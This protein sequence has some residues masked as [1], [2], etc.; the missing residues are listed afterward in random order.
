ME[1]T[2]VSSNHKTFVYDKIAVF[3]KHTDYHG[4]VHPYNFLE[5]MSYTREAYFSKVCEDFRAILDSPVKMMT[6]KVD[7]TNYDDAIFGDPI[8]AKLTI[9]KIKKVSFDVIIRFLNGRT[10]KMICETR[11]T[12]VFVDSITNGFTAI[13]KGLYQAVIEYQEN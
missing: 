12:L 10:K 4:F 7:F 9:A 2:E 13:P 5:W 3:F 11:H 8:E 6:A 1:N